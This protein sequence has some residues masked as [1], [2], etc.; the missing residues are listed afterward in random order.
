MDLFDFVVE[1]IWNFELCVYTFVG[2]IV[3]QLLRVIVVTI[4]VLLVG[5][6]IDGCINTPGPTHHESSYR[7]GS[8]R[9][10]RESSP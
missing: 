2:H 9:L 1:S 10:R 5:M 7:Y 3:L 4:P 6:F 8:K